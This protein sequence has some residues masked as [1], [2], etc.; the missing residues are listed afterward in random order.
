MQKI[1]VSSPPVIPMRK[2]RW[3]LVAAA[4]SIILMSAGAYFFISKKTSDKDGIVRANNRAGSYKNDIL[5]G[6]NKAILK[7]ADGSTIVLDDAQ[8]G[9]LARQG[10]TKVIKLDGKLSYNSGHN[11][12]HEILYNSI[13]TPRGGQYEVCL[14][15][16]SRV[17]LNAAS[18]LRFPTVFTG[19]ER[20][21][22]ITGEAY[23]EITK[24]KTMPFIVSANTAE[25]RVMGTH[26]NVMAYNEEAAMKTTLLE[27]SVR[28]ISGKDSSLLKPGQQ[29]Q[30][31]NG[32]Q[33][34]VISHVD[35]E[36]VMAWKN[37]MFYFGNADLET[38]MKQL[39]RW[40]D[41]EVSY[42]NKSFK[43]LFVGEM[44]RSSKLSDV[45]K[46]LELAGN[47]HFDIEGKK[48]IV[49]PE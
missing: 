43:R 36:E 14:P 5:P 9:V 35:M 24:S 16:G 11:S 49:M 40:Y 32:R 28:L 22:E 26:F 44:P 38:V 25:I 7:L 8:N 37:G 6:G 47:L 12:A 46:A 1:A 13:S 39:S 21:V 2:N 48:I 17:W 42:Q 34:R 45:L 4:A 33:I 15:D 27:G 29:A 18:S 20:R 3:F 31:T 19:K 23:F 30:L 10:M 41:V